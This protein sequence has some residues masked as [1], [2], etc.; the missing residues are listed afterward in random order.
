[1]PAT[2]GLLE[3]TDSHAS[4][5]GELGRQPGRMRKG[6]GRERGFGR[7]TY[8]GTVVVAKEKIKSE[9]PLKQHGIKKAWESRAEARGAIINNEICDSFS[10]I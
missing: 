9:V 4:Q 7:E 2:N 5:S 3:N 10:L 1:M 6:A 8:K